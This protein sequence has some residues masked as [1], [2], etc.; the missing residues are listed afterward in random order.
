MTAAPF[1][2]IQLLVGAAV[3]ISTFSTVYF[4]TAT[5]TPKATGAPSAGMKLQSPKG[6]RW[7]SDKP[8]LVLVIKVGC[9]HCEK[10]MDFYERLL[11]LEKK[12]QLG[13]HLVAFLPNSAADVE[14]AF[15]WRLKGLEKIA[16]VDVRSL[17]VRGTP[18]LLLIDQRGEIRSTWAGEL[19]A[20]QKLLMIKAL[21]PENFGTVR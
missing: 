3:L 2:K 17:S 11:E 7:P 9:E 18:T 5:R 20:D 12:N 21:S 19:S 16:N 14:G 6:Y 1:A 15:S 4:E 8:T 10:E 13:T